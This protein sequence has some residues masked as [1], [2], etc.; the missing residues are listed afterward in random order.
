MELTE[1]D[2]EYAIAL[3]GDQCFTKYKFPDKPTIEKLAII[4]AYLELERAKVL[5]LIANARPLGSVEFSPGKP[6]E[7]K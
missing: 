6:G 7:K 1:T 2:Y 3:K 5:N 4:A